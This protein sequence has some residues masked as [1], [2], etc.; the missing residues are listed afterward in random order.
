MKHSQRRIKENETEIEMF[1]RNL[2]KPRAGAFAD[3]LH[4]PEPPL[5]VLIHIGLHAVEVPQQTAMY[6][7]CAFLMALKK[8]PLTPILTALRQILN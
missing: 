7:P 4:E 8:L 2:L 6:S 5:E 1:F 3:A